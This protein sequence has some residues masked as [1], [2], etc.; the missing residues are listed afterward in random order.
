MT[1]PDRKSGGPT[2]WPEVVAKF[3]P[4]YSAGLDMYDELPQELA[5]SKPPQYAG[6][7]FGGFDTSLAALV[8]LRGPD[9]VL[10]A[11]RPIASGLAHAIEEIDQKKNP[12]DRNRARPALYTLNV[13]NVARCVGATM[14]RIPVNPEQ[15]WLPQLAELTSN[16]NER[17]RHTLALASCAAALTTLVPPF[18]DLPITGQPFVPQQTF[19]FNVTGFCGYLAS[20]IE[21]GETYQNVEPAWLDFVHR[22][23]FKLDTGMLGWPALLWAARAVYATLGDLPEDEVALELHHLVTGA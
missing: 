5:S 9:L 3:A 12:L 10:N 15:R 6:G 20:A 2:S 1:P 19:G 7:R 18:A 23:P 14:T 11:L 13:L 22:F 16:M 4:L 21:H 17:E 8:A